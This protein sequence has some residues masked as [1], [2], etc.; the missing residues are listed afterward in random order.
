MEISELYDMIIEAFNMPISY[1]TNSKKRV[2][3]IYLI[4][5]AIL[6]YYVYYKSKSKRT[7]FNYLLPKKIWLSRS[8]FVDYLM[9]FFNS[10]IKILVIAPYL[11]FGLYIA[12]YTN[13]Y[14]LAIFGY[15][16]VS[17]GKSK[18]IILYTIALTIIG[19]FASYLMHYLMHKIPFLWEFHKVHHSARKLTP[20]TQY[21]IHPIELIIN[22]V[23]EILIFGVLT[24]IFDYLSDNQVHKIM[25]IGVNIFGFLFMFFGANLRHSHVKLTYPIFL[26]KIIISPFQHQ[27]HHSEN[28][29][30]YNKNLGSKF[31]FWDLMFGTLVISKKVTN[32]K[33]GLGNENDDYD[34]FIKNLVVPFKRIINSI[35]F[36]FTNFG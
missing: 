3:Y 22:N 20:M 15:P 18:T 9:V 30:H 4:T 16:T 19:D 12:Y 17:L 26:E 27:I 29:E 31:A 11:I 1:L 32:L 23:K 5:S 2:Y 34:T 21:R 6:A 28:P 7:F 8:A 25:F 36:Y 10:F 24:G 14:L 35:K 33:F 13:E